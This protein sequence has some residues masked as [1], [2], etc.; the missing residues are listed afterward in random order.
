MSN[1]TQVFENVLIGFNYHEHGD[2]GENAL[3]LDR[4]GIPLVLLDG[5]SCYD[6]NFEH[7]PEGAPGQVFRCKVEA[8]EHGI[9]GISDYDAGFHILEAVKVYDPVETAQRISELERLLIV[10]RTRYVLQHV[11]GHYAVAFV[12]KT[13]FSP[14]YAKP[15]SNDRRDAYK[16]LS[17]E[18][19]DRRRQTMSLA[20]NWKVVPIPGDLTCSEPV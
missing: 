8:W 3:I 4:A 11:D 6:N 10:E 1:N 17:F 20:A 16:F 2:E 12:E 7:V 9:S 14:A 19:A 18:A 15:S 13:E 5:F